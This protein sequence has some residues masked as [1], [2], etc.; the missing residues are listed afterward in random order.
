MKQAEAWNEQSDT[1]LSAVGVF[2]NTTLDWLI[3]YL[4]WGR[5]CMYMFHIIVDNISK[6]A[7]VILCVVEIAS[8]FR[9]MYRF[10]W[11]SYRLEIVDPIEPPRYYIYIYIY[12]YIY[13]SPQ[14]FRSSTFEISK[15]VTYIVQACTCSKGEGIRYS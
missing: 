2:P 1:V 9:I 6:A 13:M 15:S 12:I 4:M 5:M 8:D 7:S 3:L 14:G 10:S 11:W